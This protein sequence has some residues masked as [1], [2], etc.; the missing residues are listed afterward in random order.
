MINNALLLET[1]RLYIYVDESPPEAG[2]VFDGPVGNKDIDYTGSASMLINWQGFID[3]ESGIMFYHIGVS[4]TCMTADN[5]SM[6]TVFKELDASEIDTSFIL[7]D[8]G[9]YFATVIAYN[10]AVMASIPVCS[11]G[12]TYDSTPAQIFNVSLRNAKI[13][14]SFACDS[15]GTWTIGPTATKRKLNSSCCENCQ[16]NC[17]VLSSSTMLLLLPEVT[18][19]DEIEECDHLLD[20][21]D[22]YAYLPNDDVH[23]TWSISDEESQLSQVFVGFGRHPT[24]SSTPDILGFTETKQNMFFRKHHLGIGNG[25]TFFIFIKAINRASIQ[26]IASY[27]PVLIVETKPLCNDKP[28]VTVDRENVTVIWE[29]SMITELNQILDIGILYHKIGEYTLYFV[30][31][32]CR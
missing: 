19:S 14:E 16:L 22:V 6:S 7:Q 27:G 4:N 25:D 13:P 1:K 10:K 21:D 8:V 23:L 9:K 11:D 26:S 15:E 29:N 5:I 3:H 18:I 32:I 17:S 2:V 20:F 24:S 28:I 12:F 31:I 30:N